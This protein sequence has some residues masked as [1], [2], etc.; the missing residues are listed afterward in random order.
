MLYSHKMLTIYGKEGREEYLGDREDI[1]VQLNNL[2]RA[3]SV[4]GDTG[5]SQSMEHRKGL[6]LPEILTHTYNINSTQCD[7]L[8]FAS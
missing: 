8:G 5:T 7:G 6:T 2:H 4:A 1:Y 3:S